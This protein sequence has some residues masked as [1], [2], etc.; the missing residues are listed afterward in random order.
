MQVSLV[1]NGHEVRGYIAEDGVNVSEV[2][3]LKKTITTLDGRIHQ[4]RIVKHKISV[5]LLDMSDSQWETLVGYF[6]T[7]PVVVNYSNFETGLTLTG[8]FYVTGLG[9]YKIKKGIGTMAYLNSLGF[10]L[11]EQ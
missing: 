11:E 3:R 9:K 1:I 10:D 6:D 4:S 8:P 5:T 2:E 7:N